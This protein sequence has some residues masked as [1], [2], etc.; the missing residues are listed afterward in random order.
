MSFK[1][2]RFAVASLIRLAARV[3][4]GKVTECSY[5]N[6]SSPLILSSIWRHLSLS[7]TRSLNTHSTK[8]WSSCMFRLWPS[9]FHV[10]FFSK[11]LWPQRFWFPLLAG[12][13]SLGAQFAKLRMGLKHLNFSKTSLSPKG[14][15]LCTWSYSSKISRYI[16]IDLWQMW[17]LWV[18]HSLLM[19]IFRLNLTS[20]NPIVHLSVSF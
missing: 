4:L 19:L 13:S 6:I 5:F 20:V 10:S 1:S 15:C 8:Y 2:S 3:H 9:N 14:L 11:C 17:S 12:I 7:R 16:Y 18:Y